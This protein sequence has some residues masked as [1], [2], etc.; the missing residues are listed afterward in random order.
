M[1]S[2]HPAVV[3]RFDFD[4]QRSDRYLQLT[5][6]GE[7]RWTDAPDAATVFASMREA[8]RA[9]VRLPAAL[10]A[11]GMPRQLTPPDRRSLH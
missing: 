4:R 1:S 3:S 7:A 5:S 2:Q 8:N 10:R 6:A 11:F 9:A